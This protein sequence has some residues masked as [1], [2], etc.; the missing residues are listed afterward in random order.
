MV[1]RIYLEVV[2]KSWRLEVRVGGE[3]SQAG[4]DANFMAG[5]HAAPSQAAVF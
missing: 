1:V 4:L 5:S 3:W 2:L